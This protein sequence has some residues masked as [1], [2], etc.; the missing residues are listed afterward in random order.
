[1]GFHSWDYSVLLIALNEIFS[2]TFVDRTGGPKHV[3]Y[4]GVVATIEAIKMLKAEDPEKIAPKLVLISSLGVTRPYWPIY[5]M[6]NTLG[7]RVMTYKLRGEDCVRS[8][9]SEIDY[10]IIRPGRLV[11]SEKNPQLIG[12]E[13]VIDQG[14]KITGQILREDVAR[15]AL[16]AVLNR[17]AG[18]KT[19]F[20]LISGQS[21]AEIKEEHRQNVENAFSRSKDPSNMLSNLKTDF[22][23]IK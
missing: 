21:G 19:T 13:L 4:G 6:L 20:E 7:G 2:L 15:V 3:D 14:D 8:A 17:D 1:M 23:L 16:H 9:G 5:I 10:T 18:N 11:P 22:Q 12:S